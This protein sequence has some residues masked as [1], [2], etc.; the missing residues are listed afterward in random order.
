M[1]QMQLT[2]SY[3]EYDLNDGAIPQDI[4]RLIDKSIAVREGA[5]A[6]YS[7]FQVGAALLLSDGSVVTGNNQENGAYPSGL[8]AERVAMFYAN[9]QYPHLS[10]RAI[11]LAAG[12]GADLTQSPITPCGACRQVMLESQGRQNHPI[13]VWM[14]GKNKVIK[15]SSVDS[16]MTFA[17]DGSSLK[18]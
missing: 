2:I 14:V 16:L 3:W 7:R 15:L 5:Y 13:E 10:I 12:E 1:P 6:P 4:Q 9:A 17:F 11:A 8:C 18:K